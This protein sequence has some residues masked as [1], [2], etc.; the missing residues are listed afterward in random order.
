MVLTVRHAVSLDTNEYSVHAHTNTNHS[1][2][3]VTV[4]HSLSVNTLKQAIPIELR[5][6]S[7]KVNSKFQKYFLMK[8]NLK[9]KIEEEETSIGEK[10]AHQQIKLNYC[11]QCEQIDKGIIHNCRWL[12]FSFCRLRCLKRFYRKI[13]AKCDLCKEDLD[14]RRIHVRDDV[15]NDTTFVFICDQCFDR[16]TTLAVHCHCCLKVCYK[17]FGAR[18]LTVSGLISKYLCSS[19]CKTESTK[20][21][22]LTIC[23]VCGVQ[24]KC[25]PILNDGRNYDTCTSSM[26]VETFEQ[27]HQ[28]QIGLWNT[29]L[30][31]LIFF[32]T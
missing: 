12:H 10:M 23:S 20:V 29:F 7:A 28:I 16:R 6:V 22:R 14:F 3:T 11:A 25:D 15:I 19:D 9:T 21:T 26:C 24:G 4:L 5:S 17:G 2:L 1:K 27:S 31:H 18:G 8:C 30:I 13:A 32:K